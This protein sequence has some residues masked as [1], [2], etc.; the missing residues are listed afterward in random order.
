[1]VSGLFLG[2]AFCGSPIVSVPSSLLDGIGV[3]CLGVALFP[4]DARG[5]LAGALLLA[6][7]AFAYCNEVY[8]LC[9]GRSRW[10]GFVGLTGILVIAL[11][12]HFGVIKSRET[13]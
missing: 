13:Q 9:T 7:I 4:K 5:R 8:L 2:C 1:M 6:F 10:L 12:T 3:F 11:L